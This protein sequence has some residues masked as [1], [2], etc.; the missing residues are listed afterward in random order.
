ME[1][2]KRISLWERWLQL[3][4]HISNADTVASL[5]EYARPWV[6]SAVVAAIFGAWGFLSRL[7]VPLIAAICLFVFAV[8]FAIFNELEN[9]K[10]RKM[11]NE[12][13]VKLG[14]RPIN[15]IPNAIEM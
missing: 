10:A 3:W 9:R 14:S 2:G 11:L 15:R 5:F 1:N 8:A 7:P 13:A 12:A 4:R 6:G